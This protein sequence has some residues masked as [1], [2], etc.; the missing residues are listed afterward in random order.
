MIVVGRLR[1]LRCVVPLLVAMTIVAAAPP[2]VARFLGSPVS[3]N[4][5]L[6]EWHDTPA[7]TFSGDPDRGDRLNAA[8]FRLAWDARKLYVAADVKDTELFASRV[9]DSSKIYSDDGI[10]LFVDRGFDHGEFMQEDDYHLMVSIG[11]S[12]AFSHGSSRLH[13][14]EEWT[15]PQ[16]FDS[17]ADLLRFVRL[18]GTPNDALPDQGYTVELAIDWSELGGVP[19]SGETI[20][21]GLC[22]DDRDAPFGPELVEDAA[23]PMGR[24]FEAFDHGGGHDFGYPKDWLAVRFVGDVPMRAR[25]EGIATPRRVAVSL[26][27][28]VVLLV[29]VQARQRARARLTLRRIHEEVALELDFARKRP[30]AMAPVTSPEPEAPAP[31]PAAAPT[32]IRVAPAPT[33]AREPSAADRIASHLLEHLAEPLTMEG[34][35]RELGLSTKTMERILRRERSTTYGALLTAIRMER[36]RAHLL[37]SDRTVTEVAFDVGFN[38]SSYFTK[39][40]RRTY[41]MSPRELRRAV[42]RER[43]ANRSA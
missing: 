10:E 23:L 25:L 19:R 32:P 22:V 43:A 31:P 28:V 42:E 12:A 36:A 27:L 21:I 6:S 15:V 2:R 33:E 35:A 5:D 4:G 38:D 3:I 13:D 18:R 20:G 34:V 24:G 8:S 14:V 41:G 7:V 37:A 30:L 16:E 17:S 26:G 40:F 11:G 1:R 39:V 9:E 29:I